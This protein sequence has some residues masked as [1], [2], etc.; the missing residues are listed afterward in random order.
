MD[1]VG[2]GRSAEER[3]DVRL[4]TAGAGQGALLETAA[5]GGHQP[6]P[7]VVDRRPAAAADHQLQPPVLPDG[8]FEKRT[9]RG[10][11]LRAVR[12]QEAADRDGL[13]SLPDAQDAAADAHAAAVPEAHAGRG[14]DDRRADGHDAVAG[15]RRLRGREQTATCGPRAAAHV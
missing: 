5:P 14:H 8:L 10:R 2:P 6:W 13:L 15:R 12:A 3:S 9:D 4:P 7:S 1:T 11:H